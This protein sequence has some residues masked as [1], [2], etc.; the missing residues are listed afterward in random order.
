MTAPATRNNRNI[1]RRNEEEEEEVER[2]M[3]VVMVV[4]SWATRAARRGRERRPYS[5]LTSRTAGWVGVRWPYPMVVERLQ[6]KV[7]LRCSGY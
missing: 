6:R 1:K 3:M 5:R 2:L 7:S 4:V